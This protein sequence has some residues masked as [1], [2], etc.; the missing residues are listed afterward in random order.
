MGD[1]LFGRIRRDIFEEVMF[2]I[3]GEFFQDLLFTIS[4]TRVGPE[5]FRRF[6]FDNLEEGITGQN[7]FILGVDRD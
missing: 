6:L 7:K 5:I 2:N 4:K 3:D 1:R